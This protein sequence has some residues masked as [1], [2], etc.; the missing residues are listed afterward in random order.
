MKYEWDW[1]YFDRKKV[2]YFLDFDKNTYVF[3]IG[4]LKKGILKMKFDWRE[5]KITHEALC[6]TT[7]K[8]KIQIE[9]VME[10]S[11]CPIESK[12]RLIAILG[13]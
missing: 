4:C 7:E 2:A 6:K 8:L 5:N 12:K 3:L 13:G 9:K 11:I 10:I 1:E